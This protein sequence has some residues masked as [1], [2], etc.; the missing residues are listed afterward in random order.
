[1]DTRGNAVTGADGRL[2]FRGFYG[3]YELGIRGAGG[4]EVVQEVRLTKSAP[5]GA[6][7]FTE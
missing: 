4:G 3:S 6:V 2:A 5:M 7:Q 1:M